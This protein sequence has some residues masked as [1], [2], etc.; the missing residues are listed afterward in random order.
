M[1]KSLVQVQRQKQAASCIPKQH[2]EACQYLTDSAK[3]V[4]Q[5]NTVWI[6][7]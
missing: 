2:A 1:S 3:L 6:L 7:T 4:G 5:Y